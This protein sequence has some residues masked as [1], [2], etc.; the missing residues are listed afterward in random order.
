MIQALSVD[1]RQRITLDGVM[2]GYEF[3]GRLNFQNLQVNTQAGFL[4]EFAI[5]TCAVFTCNL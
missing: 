3:R 1:S 4:A 2:N 5:P